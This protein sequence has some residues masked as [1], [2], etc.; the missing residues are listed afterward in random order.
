MANMATF[1]A[2]MTQMPPNYD[3]WCIYMV[4]I[5]FQNFGKFRLFLADFWPKTGFFFADS[6]KKWK[7]MF[8][9]KCMEFLENGP[10]GLKI[11]INVPKRCYYNILRTLFLYLVFLPFYGSRNAKKGLFF[12]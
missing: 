10:I 7:K 9:G 12:C 1:C 3:I 5:D 2:K 11:G 4:F 8:G 6:A